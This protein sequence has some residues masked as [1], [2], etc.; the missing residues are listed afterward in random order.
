MIYLSVFLIIRNVSDKIYTEYQKNAF[1]FTFGALFLKIAHFM[2]KFEK[3][4]SVIHRP[5]ATI[6]RMRTESR[7]HKATNTH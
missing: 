1:F 2:R 5:Q 7:I 4:K 6:R 3:K